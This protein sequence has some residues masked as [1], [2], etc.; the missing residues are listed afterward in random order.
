MSENRIKILRKRQTDKY[1]SDMTTG[2]IKLH[3][4]L[5][6]WCLIIRDFNQLKVDKLTDVTR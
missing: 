5:V 4:Y 1:F 3:L 6:V 2:T